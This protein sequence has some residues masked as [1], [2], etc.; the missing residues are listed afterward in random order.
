[1]SI[2]LN[3]QFTYSEALSYQLLSSWQPSP[4]IYGK[5]RYQN[6]EKVLWI[7]ITCSRCL[8]FWGM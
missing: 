8:C 6:C 3:T 2:N 1:M 7:Q 4:N 5:K